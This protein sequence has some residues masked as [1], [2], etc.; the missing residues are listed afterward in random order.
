MSAK[1]LLTADEQVRERTTDAEEREIGLS[2]GLE[3]RC[4]SERFKFAFRCDRDENH[5][6]S[7]LL[8]SVGG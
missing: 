2:L 1:L 5:V 7:W 4:M 6:D 8:N 3:E